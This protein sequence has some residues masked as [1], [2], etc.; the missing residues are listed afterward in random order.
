MI[1]A[2]I[3]RGQADGDGRGVTE[4]L[5]YAIPDQ[6]DQTMLFE[7]LGYCMTKDTHACRNS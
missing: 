4:I 3:Y 5:S 7:Y 6:T 1:F 2:L